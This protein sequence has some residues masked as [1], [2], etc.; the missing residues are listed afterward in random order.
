VT[1]ERG[2]PLPRWAAASVASRAR[3]AEAPRLGREDVLRVALAE[4]PKAASPTTRI[5]HETTPA[6]TMASLAIR[7]R[8]VDSHDEARPM[9]HRWRRR[10]QLCS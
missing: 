6:T 10:S 4:A 1:G 7:L 9:S 8:S 3:R 2:S 5:W